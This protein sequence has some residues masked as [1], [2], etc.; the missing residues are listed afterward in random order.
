MRDADYENGMLTISLERVVPEA[1]KPRKI[2]IGDRGH[3][4]DDPPHLTDNKAA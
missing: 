3:V 2:A 1:M 4:N